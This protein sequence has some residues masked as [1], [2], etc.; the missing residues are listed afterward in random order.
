M[1]IGNAGR[2]RDRRR[3]RQTRWGRLQTAYGSARCVPCWLLQLKHGDGRRAQR[4]GDR[5]LNALCHGYAYVSTAALPAAPFV[6]E[7][8]DCG[9]PLA[10]ET[11]LDLL[12]G[13]LWGTEPGR[14][15]LEEWHGELRAM[16][17]AALPRVRELT[18]DVDHEVARTARLLLQELDDQRA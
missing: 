6:V 11:A 3:L 8:L 12:R 2:R 10:R 5:L 14:S 4:A 13:F 9:E 17:L 7:A 16:T 15:D 18:K 1:W